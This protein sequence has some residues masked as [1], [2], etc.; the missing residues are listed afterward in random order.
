MK[1]IGPQKRAAVYQRACSL[2]FGFSETAAKAD[3]IDEVT[4]NPVFRKLRDAT[5]PIRR[6]YRQVKD[7]HL[8]VKA[9]FKHSL[10]FG[11][12]ANLPD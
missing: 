10:S 9:I 7:H 4:A 11:R 5:C 8:A 1:E 2:K 3:R 12:T 6:L